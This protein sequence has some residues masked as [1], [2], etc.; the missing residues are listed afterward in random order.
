MLHFA[1]DTLDDAV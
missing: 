1:P